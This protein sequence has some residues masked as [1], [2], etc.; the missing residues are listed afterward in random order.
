LGWD[1][2]S[3]KMILLFFFVFEKDKYTL[4]ELPLWKRGAGGISIYISVY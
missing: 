2:F 4:K 3:K 1:Y